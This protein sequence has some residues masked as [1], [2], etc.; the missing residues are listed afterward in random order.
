MENK[1]EAISALTR[2]CLQYCREDPSIFF[3]QLKSECEI[4]G[5][6]NQ[7]QKYLAVSKLPDEAMA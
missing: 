7:K 1:T 2:A 5:I 6:S 3:K 4:K